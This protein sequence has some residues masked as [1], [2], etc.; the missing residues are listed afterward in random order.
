MHRGFKA[1]RCAFLVLLIGAGVPLAA[2]AAASGAV[3]PPGQISVTPQDVVE[4]STGNTLTFSYAPGAHRLPDGTVSVKVPKGWTL[5]VTNAPGSPGNVYVSAG[6]VSVSKRLITVTNVTLCKSSC[7]L[8]LIYSDASA[9]ATPGIDRF[10]TKV[11]NAGEPLKP[12]TPTPG[13]AVGETAPCTPQPVTMLGPPSLTATPGT[14][15]SGGTVIALTGTGFAPTS[16]GEIL[17]CNDDPSQPTVFLSGPIN[18][19]F[20]VSC[21]GVSISHAVETHADGSLATTWTAISGTTGPPCGEPG[22]LAA[23]CPSDSSGGNTPADAADY[24]CPPTPAQ[25]A[26]GVSC[27]LSFGSGSPKMQTVDISF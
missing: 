4:G 8:T 1:L 15:L 27:T 11:A 22:D 16:L 3:K 5:P 20:P 18:E 2:G 9:S 19:A 17:Q 6:T 14:C 24:P 13:V 21:T 26:I 7:S 12:L 23:T 10:P 25:L